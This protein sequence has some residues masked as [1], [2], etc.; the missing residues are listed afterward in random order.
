M[1]VSMAQATV[2]EGTLREFPYLR[3]KVSS[4]IFYPLHFDFSK[5]KILGV[6]FMLLL[7]FQI[8]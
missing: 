5:L 4:W 8:S 6:D 2:P 3:P 1:G 7:V